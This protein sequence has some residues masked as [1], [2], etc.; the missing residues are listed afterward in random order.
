VKENE[1]VDTN[2]ASKFQ[3]VVKKFCPGSKN[4]NAD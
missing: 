4:I 2:I 1:F 3:K